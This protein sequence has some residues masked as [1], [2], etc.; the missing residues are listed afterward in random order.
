[1]ELEIKAWAYD[2]FSAIHE[3]EI[4]L[5]DAPTFEVY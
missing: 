4:F 5:A 2:I 1:M 3:I